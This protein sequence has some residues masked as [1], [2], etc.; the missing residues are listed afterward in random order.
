MTSCCP[1]GLLGSR[2]RTNLPDNLSSL[3]P[4]TN[5]APQTRARPLWV[6]VSL[7][8]YPSRDVMPAGVMGRTSFRPR[9]VA[10]KTRTRVYFTA[11]AAP[12]IPP[13][14]RL[15]RPTYPVTT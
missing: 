7:P 1:L 13:S 10:H 9:P 11:R 15:M 2:P 4:P 5:P 8:A 14:A 3:P 6:H 12:I